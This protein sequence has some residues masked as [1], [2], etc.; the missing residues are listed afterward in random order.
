MILHIAWIQTWFQQL[1]LSGTSLDDL[2]G[3]RRYTTLWGM[4]EGFPEILR[5]EKSSSQLFDAAPPITFRTNYCS[6][7]ENG[8]NVQ[9]F[10]AEGDGA[11]P[12]V[13]EQTR[14]NFCSMKLRKSDA[15]SVDRLADCFAGSL[16]I[17]DTNRQC[18]LRL[19]EFD[20]TLFPQYEFFLDLKDECFSRNALIRA[21]LSAGS[22]VWRYYSWRLIARLIDLHSASN[23]EVDGWCREVMLCN[24]ARRSRVFLIVVRYRSKSFEADIPAY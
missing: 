24:G 5:W 12:A 16:R 8:V 21:S 3:K 19:D 1:Q 20:F 7:N 15:K 14:S 13:S 6:H 23:Q 17:V 9:V 18:F 4:E 11:E 22:S 2:P 10:E